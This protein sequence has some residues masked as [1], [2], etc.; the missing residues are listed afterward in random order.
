MQVEKKGLNKKKRKE[1][2]TKERKKVG[3]IATHLLDLT[4]RKVGTS[5]LMSF[6][7]LLFET[8]QGD[9]WSR[10]VLLYGS[11]SKTK[12]TYHEDFML[13]Y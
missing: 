13:L 10:V 9:Y 8:L 5:N 11:N 6:F 7:N 12:Y 4:E 2:K 1:R 3:G